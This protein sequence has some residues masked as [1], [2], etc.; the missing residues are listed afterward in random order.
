MGASAGRPIETLLEG[1]G[2]ELTEVER[3]RQSYPLFVRR[4]A[5][6][7]AAAHERAEG[8]KR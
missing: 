4:V 6:A 7:V 8:G 1:A 3:R 2:W 5:V